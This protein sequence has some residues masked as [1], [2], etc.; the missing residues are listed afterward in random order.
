MKPGWDSVELKGLS[1]TQD[2]GTPYVLLELGDDARVV[3]IPVGM[4]EAQ[5]VLES[6]DPEV[7]ADTAYDVLQD[8]MQQQGLAARSL[9][10]DADAQGGLAAVLSYGEDVASHALALSVSRGLA[11]AAKMRVPVYIRRQVARRL[12]RSVQAS[13]SGSSAGRPELR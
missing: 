7:P 11:V 8:L 12:A 5:A 4:H 1:F 3:M 13:S 6:L 9:E 10:I 2:P